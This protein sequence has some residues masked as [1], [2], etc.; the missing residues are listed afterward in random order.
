[1][2]IEIFEDRVDCAYIVEDGV[3]RIIP[4]SNDEFF[5][6][7]EA[8]NSQKNMQE[9]TNVEVIN[10]ET[11]VD[12]E[13]PETVPVE[14]STEETTETPTGEET[15]REDE[16]VPAGEDVPAEDGEVTPE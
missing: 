13:T 7:Q 6:K 15:P 5:I 12:A 8:F 1:M 10:E 9:D 4:K 16:T 14:E 3:A 11:V 2:A